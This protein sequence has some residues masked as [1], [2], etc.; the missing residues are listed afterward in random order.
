MGSAATYADV[1]ICVIDDNRN[2]QNIFRALLR[3]MGFRRVDVFSDPI[4]ARTFVTDTPID[5]T[6]IDLVMPRETGVDWVRT[7]RRSSL[8]ANPTMPIALVSGHVDRKVLEAAVH[9]GVDD[10]LVK[11]L[12][13]AT[14]HRHT[15]RL[16]RHPTPYVRGPNGYFGPNLRGSTGRAKADE[17]ATTT[18]TIP[19]RVDER[20]RVYDRAVP[21]LNVEKRRHTGYD[22]EQTFLD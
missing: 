16:L 2:F 13:P 15:M 5:I 1:R 11:P 3:G 20:V 10:V 8:L 14:L 7:V 4:E 12:S 22:A 18:A 17:R 9:A 21:G 6:F 19:H